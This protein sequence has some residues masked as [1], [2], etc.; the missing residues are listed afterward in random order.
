MYFKQ[1]DK[2]EVMKGPLALYIQDNVQRGEAKSYAKLKKMVESYIDQKTRERHIAQ[3][4]KSSE[5]SFVA[6]K[7]TPKGTGKG[8][9]GDC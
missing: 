8:Q 9:V 4:E 2:S 3:R 6:N 5:R 7:G 1:L